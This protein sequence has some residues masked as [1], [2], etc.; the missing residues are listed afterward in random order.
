[1]SHAGA[2]AVPLHD[3]VM[4]GVVYRLCRNKIPKLAIQTQ[5]GDDL[6]THLVTPSFHRTACDINGNGEA[7][8]H[9]LLVGVLATLLCIH[10]ISLR[11][12]AT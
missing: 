1:M 11:S 12:N 10:P 4:L 2:V 9:I 8:Y 3:R 5:L 6:I 7:K